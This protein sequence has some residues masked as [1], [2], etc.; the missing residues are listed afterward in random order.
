MAKKICV[1]GTG[2]VG[3]IAAI[4]LS[5]FGNTVIG[6]DIDQEKVDTLTSGKTPI[7]EPGAVEYLQRNLDS[8]RLSFT[9]D[10]ARAIQESEVILIAVGTPQGEDGSADLKYV[11]TVA[12]TIAENLNNYKVIVTKSTVPVGTNR[13]ILDRIKELAPGKEFDVVSNPEFL[14]EGRATQD[15]FHPDRTVIGYESEK[16]KEIMHDVYRALNL[17][18]VPFV[19]CNLETAEL[20]KYASN[21]FLA[22]KITFINQ[23][24]NL[25]DAVG[26]DVHLVSKTM[27][28]DGR[29]SSKFLH[30]GPGYGG[31]CFPKDTQALVKIGSD[32]GVE[33]ELIKTVISANEN[34]KMRMFEKLNKAFNG[35]LEGKTIAVLGLTFK[36]ETDDIRESPSL[37]MVE[38]LL[39]AGARV[40][41]YDAKGMEN[42]S[43]L[44]PQV[45]YCNSSLDAVKQADAMVL[46]TEW[47]EFRALDLVEIKKMMSGNIIVDTRNLL[48]PKYA[49]DHGFNYT[50]VGRA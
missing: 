40:Q 20:I 46:M 3:L 10:S 9:T 34:Q 11:M 25:A 49:K 2:Y 27:G 35:N 44:Y 36:Q 17:I 30:P 5:D 12:D 4:G 47:N 15:F 22:T 32:F 50:G 39:E 24:A 8:G 18:S 16:A 43:K 29:I 1:V 37:T 14:R 41:A 23:M 31:S 33:M 13:K 7:Y 6:V 21:T 38:Q 26:A 28:M 45:L 19:W 48:D 42:F